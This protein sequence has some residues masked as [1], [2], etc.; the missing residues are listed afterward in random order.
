MGP[1]D[2]DCAAA[3]DVTGQD[4]AVNRTMTSPELQ[5]M[6]PPGGGRR[7]LLPEGHEGAGASPYPPGP[8]MVI[9]TLSDSILPSSVQTAPWTVQTV[10]MGRTTTTSPFPPGSTVI[11]HSRFGWM[12]SGS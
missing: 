7:P 12:P 10:V 6:P 8:G 3:L 1:P 9:A 4:P 11:C 2:V 5:V